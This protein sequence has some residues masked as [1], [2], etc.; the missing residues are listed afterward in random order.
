MA[1]VTPILIQNLASQTTLSDSDYFIVGGADAKKITVAQMKEALGINEL[2]GNLDNRA[3][4]V[5]A[6][7]NGQQN[8][9]VIIQ[10]DETDVSDLNRIPV[11]VGGNIASQ[12]FLYLYNIDL[13][14]LPTNA[15]VQT[16][17]AILEN[18]NFR[19]SA[20]K[21][22]GNLR[23]FRL[24]FENLG[25]VGTHFFITVYAHGGRVV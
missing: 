23:R 8:Y 3:I 21:D 2:N 16:G 24:R 18:T 12:N 7:V 19:L 13:P 14:S 9:A 25:S 11:M 20:N 5:D 6:W 22:G 4:S 10:Y 15:A 1:D 17:S